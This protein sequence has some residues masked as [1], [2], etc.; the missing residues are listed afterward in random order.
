MMIRPFN[1][2]DADYES[3]ISLRNQLYPDNPS[4]VEIW[5]HNDKVRRRDPSYH[6]FLV[7][8]DAGEL[9]AFV[10]FAL[11]NPRSKKIAFGIIAQNEAWHD[12]TASSLMAAMAGA[13]RKLS[14][15]KLVCKVQEND[16]PKVSYLEENGFETVMRYPIS[17]LTVASFDPT[18]FTSKIEETERLGI[19]V[20]QLPAG[21]Q[22]DAKWQALVHDLDWQLMLDVPSHE[23]RMQSPLEKFLTEEI[24]HPNSLTESYFI[25]WDN[26]EAVGLTCFVKRGGRVETVSTLL[27]GVLQSHRRR[28][29]A[30]ALKIESIKFARNF[31]IQTIL[32]NNEENNPMFIL[33]QQLGFQQKPA[34]IN[35]EKSL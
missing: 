30:R 2:T 34:W 24:F 10:Q 33:N 28:G 11:N 3:A 12:G 14:A 5:K 26:D 6:F 7:E 13:S 15:E 17:A 29:I 8:S 16:Q 22:H 31:G 4:T 23:P 1:F 9:R 20:R 35:L 19:E 18:P 27:T 21:W 25:A 32:T